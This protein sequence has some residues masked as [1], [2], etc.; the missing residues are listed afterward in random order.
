MAFQKKPDFLPPPGLADF[1]DPC[2][3][4]ARIVSLIL[5]LPSPFLSLPREIPPSKA[6]P[7]N[8]GLAT[9]SPQ[10]IPA[11]GFPPL[12]PSPLSPVNFTPRRDNA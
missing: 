6:F 2:L 5:A 4:Q 1:S 11:V 12:I 7:P 9:P 8:M 3:I 10:Q